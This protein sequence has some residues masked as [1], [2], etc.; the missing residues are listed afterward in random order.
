VVAVDMNRGEHL[1]RIPLSKPSPNIRNNPAIAELNLDWDSMGDF[2]IRPSPLLT[3]SLYFLGA[4]GNLAGGTGSAAFR[5][6]DKSNGKV[7]WEMDMPSLVS[8]APMTYELGG[9]QYIVV[10]I[11]ARGKPAEIVALTLDGVS[12][13]GAAPAGGVQVAAAPASARAAAQAV[14][15]TPAELALGKTKFDQMCV[16]CHGVDGK[17]GTAVGAPPVNG[18]TD[19]ANVARVI[20][21]GQG[22]MPALANSLTS[23]EI[24]AIAKHVVKTLGPQAR[25]AGRGGP[26][27]EDD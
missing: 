6:Y 10:A 14:N 25:P 19:Y 2:D 8:G 23:A 26:P 18:R 1:W 13:N 3:K 16:M 21:Q 7:I 27:P 4:S 24:D 11:S 15:A 12:G 20:A 5:A 9:R 17:G 22:E